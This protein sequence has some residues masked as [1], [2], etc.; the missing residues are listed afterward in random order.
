ML[1]ITQ[2][3]TERLLRIAPT[4]RIWTRATTEEK[5]TVSRA[6]ALRIANQILEQAELERTDLAETEAKRQ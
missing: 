3:R 4:A 1:F 5:K 2:P 6:D